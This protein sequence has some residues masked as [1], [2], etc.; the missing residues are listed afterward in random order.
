MFASDATM[1]AA[2]G[3][4]KLWPLYMFFANNSKY[5]RAR[6]SEKLFE[7]IAYF[8]NVSMRVLLVEMGWYLRDYAASR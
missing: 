5:K 4:A 7:T 8:E 2:F 6:P 3:S 1:L